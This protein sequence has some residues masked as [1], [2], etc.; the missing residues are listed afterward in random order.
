MDETATGDSVPRPGYRD[1]AGRPAYGER[2]TPEEQAKA[3]G[4]A[5]PAAGEPSAVIPDATGS[6]VTPDGS[7]DSVPAWSVPAWPASA[8]ASAAAPRAES[9]QQPAPRKA[10]RIVTIVLLSLGL[11]NVLWGIP[12]FLSLANTLQLAYDQMGVGQYGAAGL[13]GTMG[14]VAIVSQLVIWAATAWGSLQRMKRGR[15]AW[16]VPL[17]GAAVAFIV[18]AVVFTIAIL[19]DPTFMAY[20]DSQVAVQG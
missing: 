2:A 19:A 13:A 8:P 11:L 16:W 7:R 6:R 18:V 14:V 17:V 9:G 10:D 3:R 15:L 5:A 4:F 20:V 12:G 1:S